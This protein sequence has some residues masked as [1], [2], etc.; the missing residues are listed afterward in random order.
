MQK[1]GTYTWKTGLKRI[2]RRVKTQS[3]DVSAFTNNSLSEEKSKTIMTTTEVT[4]ISKKL[5]N[6][7]LQNQK[8]DAVGW[9][10]NREGI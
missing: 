10:G 9:G 5:W 4:G 8:Q 6:Q 1:G 7:G 3:G 2:S